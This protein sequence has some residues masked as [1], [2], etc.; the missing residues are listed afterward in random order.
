MATDTHNTTLSGQPFGANAYQSVAKT[1]FNSDSQTRQGRTNTAQAKPFDM[2]AFLLRI[3]KGKDQTKAKQETIY[4]P[5]LV[6]RIK[7]ALM[8]L[9]VF[10]IRLI[11]IVIFFA[12]LVMGARISTLVTHLGTKDI[13]TKA[14]AADKVK[15]TKQV[16]L[17]H[18]DKLPE[19]GGPRKLEAMDNFDPFN[20]TADQYRVLRGI[21][22]QS[23]VLND[24]E[25]SLSE[26][27]QILK[28]LL[29]KMDQKI[30]ELKKAKEALEGVVQQ[31]D[32]DENANTKRLV[33]MIEG[34]KPA[35]AAAVLQ[36]IEFPI[37]LDIMER[38]KEKK[39]ADILA[40]MDPKKAGFLMTALS[41]RRKVFK[42][43]EPK[44]SVMAG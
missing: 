5:N 2:R 1:A 31:I 28:A 13:M 33:K 23:D 7:D 10:R 8:S 41:K 27:E 44:K 29:K 15:E 35:Q 18:L 20:M 30:V 14:Y 42:K 22:D 4:K 36:D 40:N 43:G 38:V 26:K 17:S 6:S 34:M 16:P 39:A 9:F 3:L 25:R 24:R 32:E 12:I 11:P 37:L 21:A 19:A